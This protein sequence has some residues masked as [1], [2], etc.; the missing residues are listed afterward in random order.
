[1]VNNYF[2]SLIN[3]CTSLLINASII[4]IQQEVLD[5]LVNASIILGSEGVKINK[6]YSLKKVQSP[7]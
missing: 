1:M 3:S 2:K 5:L 6:S 7:D 4:L